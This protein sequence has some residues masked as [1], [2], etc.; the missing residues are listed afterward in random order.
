MKSS[1]SKPKR[2]FSLLELSIA[3]AMMAALSTASMVVLRT[4]QTSWNRHRED[5]QRTQGAAAIVR[6]IVRN[7]RQATAVTAISAPADT[8]GTLSLLQLDGSVLVWD[9]DNIND[10]VNFGETT[11]GNL[12]ANHVTQ[13]KFVGYKVDG[14]TP[15]E[16]TDLIHIIECSVT[17]EL[18]RPAGTTTQVLT[19]RAWVRSW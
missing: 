3:M 17:Y 1:S 15:T 18:N 16:E 7:V 14:T 10:Q 2:G 8:S 11:A 13:L 6:H 4:S 5:H 19:S 12:F 9:H